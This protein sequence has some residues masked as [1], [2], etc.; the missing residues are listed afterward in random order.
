MLTDFHSSFT[1]RLSRKFATKLS[2]KIPPQL[3]CVTTLPCETV[4][5]W[6]YKYSY[7][8]DQNHIETSFVSDFTSNKQTVFCYLGASQLL[9]CYNT[10]TIHA[11]SYN[12]SNTD[13]CIHSERRYNNHCE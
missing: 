5:V 11:Y 8:V 12:Y 1:D 7:T 2:L 3:S 13:I 4:I 10:A 6:V 9:H